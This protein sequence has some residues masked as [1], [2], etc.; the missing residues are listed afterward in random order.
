LQLIL[1]ITIRNIV[2]VE[3]SNERT[4]RE[5]TTM[6]AGR[7]LFSGC[8]VV[9]GGVP[10]VENSETEDALDDVVDAC[11]VEAVLGEIARRDGGATP[12][13]ECPSPSPFAAQQ[14][15]ITSTSSERPANL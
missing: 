9:V 6:P 7:V 12:V 14:K 11:E 15:E 8:C 3:A 4:V 2:N 1:I 13:V 10:G 5:L